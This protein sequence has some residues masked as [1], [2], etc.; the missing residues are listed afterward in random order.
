MI[1]V[2]TEGYED[3][4]LQGTERLF[5]A[6]LVRAV[7]LEVSPVFGPID[8]VKRFTERYTL[9]AYILGYKVGLTYR[10][11]PML[12]EEHTVG[13]QINVLLLHEDVRAPH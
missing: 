12:Y 1:K 10:P 3:E 4:V 8:Y 7:I 5:K 9:R 11:R 13:R 6:G 2:D